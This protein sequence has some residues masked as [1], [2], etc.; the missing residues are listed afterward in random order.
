MR[1]AHDALIN[2][3]DGLVIYNHLI[4]AVSESGKDPA[5]VR[6]SLLGKRLF[7]KS[8][9]APGKS[10]DVFRERKE[11]LR[12]RIGDKAFNR[13]LAHDDLIDLFNK[14]LRDFK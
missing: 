11:E 7:L 10:E 6:R 3:E 2:G 1:K 9:I 4:D 12:K 13:L 14:D 5:S 8:K